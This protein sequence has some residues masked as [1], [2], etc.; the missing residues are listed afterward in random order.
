MT[1]LIKTLA[2]AA[3]NLKN[4]LP[5]LGIFLLILIAPSIRAQSPTDNGT[6][7]GLAPGSP[8]GSYAL[9]GFENVNLYSG[10]LSFSLPALQIGGRGHAGYSVQVPIESKW[11][12]TKN[13]WYDENNNL[14]TSLTPW[15]SGTAGGGYGPGT[16]S[17]RYSQWKPETC[18]IGVQQFT[19][20]R[21]ASVSIMF[22]APDGTEHELVDQGTM[23]Q[24]TSYPSCSLNGTF[25]GPVFVSKDQPGMTF[26]AD[27]AIREAPYY[28][29]GR[30][31]GYLKMPD[32]TVYRVDAI[33]HN[34]QYYSYSTL[35][36][37]WI[38]DA[39]GNKT[40]FGYTNS[41][42][43]DVLTSVKDSLN[44]EITIEYGVNEAPYGLCDRLTYRGYA[45]GNRVIHISAGN[46]STALRN[47]STIK[48]YKQLFP[49]LDGAED[50]FDPWVLTSIWLPDGD[51][52]TRRYRF[53]YNSYGELARI[54]LPTGGAIEYDWSSGLA[55]GAA[56]GLLYAVPGL[57]HWTEFD[58]SLPQVYRRLINR[59]AYDVG[60]VLLGSTSYSRPETQNGDFSINNLG[61][62]AAGHYNANGNQLSVDNH[63][64]YG[65]VASSF[66]S[67][68][69]TPQYMP[70]YSPFASYKDGH[71]YQTDYYAA[72]G[73]TLLTRETQS[74]DQFAVSWWS[75]SAD[76]APPNNSFVKETVTTLA[77]TARL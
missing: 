36:V 19:T 31:T 65:S 35:V 68:Q 53:L 56:D 38:R 18:T 76:S 29:N 70:T 30:V 8:E 9:G 21:W 32:G 58:P 43:A 55:T 62:V 33:D 17:V 23:G 63:F 25:R 11:I 2:A 48:T 51:G 75:G 28:A 71:E 22:R 60:N 50:P 41:G 39:N 6:P 20:Y 27:A 73:Q 59:R 37:S 15:S 54:E 5:I 24:P 52:V 74:W 49:E 47:G 44:R 12:V 1:R 26:I 16:V 40:S 7:L 77:D 66:F 61:Y 57:A 67:W 72:N 14:F 46:M 10:G 34:Y 3:W 69:A 45:G 64:F 42:Y 13:E 4:T